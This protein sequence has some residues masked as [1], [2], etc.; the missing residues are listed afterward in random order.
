MFV[1][2][3]MTTSLNN[4][5]HYF[6]LCH[7]D[8][9][10][11]MQDVLDRFKSTLQ[12]N[13]TLVES[14]TNLIDL[15]V[16]SL[17]T[18]TDMFLDAATVFNGRSARAIRQAW[19]AMYDCRDGIERLEK[20]SLVKVIDGILRVHDVIKAEAVKQADNANGKVMTRVWRPD[21]ARFIAYSIAIWDAFRII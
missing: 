9:N 15:S 7:A 8:C 17:G 19:E 2:L 6:T 4:N 5:M 16:S 10:H 20:M 3:M 18:Y 1:C 12:S 13:N 21:Q 11:I 14:V